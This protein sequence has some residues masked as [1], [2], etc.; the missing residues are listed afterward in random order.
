MIQGNQA[1]SF[2]FVIL[3]IFFLLNLLIFFQSKK[4]LLW[5]KKVDEKGKNIFEKMVLLSANFYEDLKEKMGLKEFLDQKHSFEIDFKK[6]PV[7]FTDFNQKTREEAISKETQNTSVTPKEQTS[8]EVF[9]KFPEEISKENIIQTEEKLRV[10]EERKEFLEK[11]MRILIIGDSMAVVGGGLGETLEKELKKEFPN[12]KILRE[13][14]VSSGLS[15]PDYFNW[16]ARLREL[17]SQFKPS[18]TILVFGLNDCQGL[19]STNGEIV[20]SYE[21]FGQKEWEEEYGKRVRRMIEIL[22]ENNS[23]IF[24]VGLPIVKDPI[25]A[26]K[27]AILNQIYKRELAKFD[28]AIF[29]STW[30]ILCNNGRYADYFYDEKGVRQL[31]RTSDGI[32]F[33][34]LGSRI[35]SKKIIEE[36]K[37]WLNL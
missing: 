30:C 8:S 10:K 13:G 37:N 11:E 1:K 4:I 28:N 18:V 19:T 34:N 2:P 24:W 6:S 7:L 20:V 29:I 22:K 21:K 26:N 16:E 36:M 5:E 31:V 12:A 3:F 23:F 15:R 9:V 35:V 33:H 32:H 17:I 14:K 25:F 27:L